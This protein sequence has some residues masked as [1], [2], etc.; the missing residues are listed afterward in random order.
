[1]TFTVKN[2]GYWRTRRSVMQ[3]IVM[4]RHE[5][6]KTTLLRNIISQDLAGL[7]G[8]TESAAST[9]NGDLRVERGHRVFQTAAHGPRVD[10]STPMRVLNQARGRHSV[11]KNTFQCA[12]VVH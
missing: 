9:T 10:D 3:G 7:F 4:G 5:D 8:L 11:A 1:M 2:P 6:G 12:D